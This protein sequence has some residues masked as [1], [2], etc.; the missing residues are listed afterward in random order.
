MSETKLKTNPFGLPSHDD[1]IE[2]VKEEGQIRLSTEYIKRCDEVASE[3]NGWLRV[4][5]EMQ[6]DLVKRHGFNGPAFDIALNMLRSAQVLYPDNPYVKELIYVKNNKA[7][8]GRFNKDDK[9]EDIKLWDMKGSH[10]ISLFD[11]LSK[12]RTNIVLAASHT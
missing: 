2:L 3:V 4:T 12:N 5:D 6:Q 11:M 1:I 7:N 8:Q 10:Q 9:L